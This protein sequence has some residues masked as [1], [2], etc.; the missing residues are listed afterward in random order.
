[1]DDAELGEKQ[2]DELVNLRDGG[3]GAFASAPRDALLD[4]D[5]RRQPVD[6]VDIRPRHLLHKLPGIGVEGI[7]KTALALGEKYIE[8][9]RTFAGTT[10]PGD[11]NQ[12]VTGDADGD[13]AEVV[14]AGSLD[15][16]PMGIVSRFSPRG[17]GSHPL[18]GLEAKRLEAG[19][20][21]T[22]R[23]VA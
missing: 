6:G 18:G 11:H 19:L 15:T 3:D 12:L 13:V 17:H 5:R 9:Q 21:H 4:A 22:A 1:M 23:E 7:E 16:D 10:H 14:F 20:E 2:A 8:R